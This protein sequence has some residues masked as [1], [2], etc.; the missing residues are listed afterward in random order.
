MVVWNRCLSNAV[1]YNNPRSNRPERRT[2]L[3]AR[4]LARYKVDIAALSE[5]RFSELG[6][7]EVVR[8]DYIFF[9]SG[10]T[11][12]ERRDA[13]VVLAIRNDIVGRLPSLPQG[14]YDRLM[15]LRLPLRQA[16]G[17]I[18][19]HRQRL[20]SADEQP[21]RRRKG[22]ILRGPARPLGDCV[23]DGQADCLWRLQHPRRHRPYCLERSAGS[24]RS[25]RLQRQWSTTAPHLR[26]TLPHPDEH[27]LLS[28]GAREG[29]LEASSVPSVAP[30]GLRPRPEARWRSWVL[31]G[32]PT[33]AS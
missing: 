6:Q 14:I 19:H 33:M 2:A 31:T 26:R 18:R 8:A 1:C 4:E 3:V 7:R 24:P 10:R 30:A 9:W 13:G 25:P 17:R 29:H 5:A 21:R 20:R 32:G 12:T 11:R 23:E 16:W 27:V 22:K 28:V 15:S